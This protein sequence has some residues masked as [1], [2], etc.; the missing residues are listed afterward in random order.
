MRTVIALLLTSLLPKAA[1]HLMSVFLTSF[2]RS[3]AAHILMWF[4]VLMSVLL[5]LGLSGV[6]LMMGLLY[7]QFHW[8]LVA[9]PVA[10][11]L[12]LVGVWI[13]AYQLSQISPIHPRSAVGGGVL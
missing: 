12:L 6:A 1:T 2:S 9:V 4:A 8:A 3:C 5:F 7:G 10:A 13:R 11:L